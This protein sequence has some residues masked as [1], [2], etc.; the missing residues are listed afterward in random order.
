[1]ANFVFINGW[2]F[3]FFC[4]FV[5]LKKFIAI[6]FLSIYLISLTELN[7]LVKLPLLV[8]HFIEHKEKDGN[9][10]LIAFLNMHYSQTD[11]QDN[12]HDKDMQLPFKSHDGCINSITIAFIP[13]N[14][15]G[16]STKPTFTETRSFSVYHEE[17]LQST[18]LSSIWQPPKFC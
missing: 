7:Q 13:N 3:L 16:L 14:F 15:E 5:T 8:E 9:L 10:S 2:N 4:I 17:F 6:L 11:V 12:D 1:M 18:F